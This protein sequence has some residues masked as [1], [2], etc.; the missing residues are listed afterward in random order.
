MLLEGLQWYA[1]WIVLA[2]ATEELPKT[3]QKEETLLYDFFFFFVNIL[4]YQHFGALYQRWRI[5]F[6]IKV[7]FR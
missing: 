4:T 6:G 3:E 1:W 5:C 7:V 2:F